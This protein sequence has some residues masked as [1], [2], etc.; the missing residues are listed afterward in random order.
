VW[1]TAPRAK[2]PFWASPLVRRLPEIA[3]SER[4]QPTNGP[5]QRWSNGG[6]CERRKGTGVRPRP[7]PANGA[8]P[9]PPSACCSLALPPMPPPRTNV[10]FA[11]GGSRPAPRAAAP[12]LLLTDHQPRPS[13]T[14]ATPFGRWPS[15]VDPGLAS[16]ESGGSACVVCGA[17][18]VNQ[19]KKGACQR[20]EGPQSR[21]HHHRIQTRDGSPFATAGAPR[22]PTTSMQCRASPCIQ[23]AKWGG[24]ARVP[25]QTGTRGPN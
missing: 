24:A 5:A 12:A 18:F 13:L 25:S 4:P 20:G 9:D 23:R 16:M 15:S 10:R 21:P 6:R 17:G 3:A 8:L 11:A 22:P 1:R 14:P 2:A 19:E 7:I